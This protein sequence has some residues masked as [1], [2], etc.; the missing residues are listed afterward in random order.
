MQRL[1]LLKSQTRTVHRKKKQRLQIDFTAA[2]A[3]TLSAGKQ[4]IDVKDFIGII[5]RTSKDV[6][7]QILWI[8]SICCNRQFSLLT[9]VS[10]PNDSDMTSLQQRYTLTVHLVNAKA[11]QFSMDLS[12]KEATV[13]NIRSTWIDYGDG[14]QKNLDVV[15][16][17]A[18]TGL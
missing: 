8:L 18:P 6:I 9:Q 16:V 5:I 7:M 15:L 2:F 10:S 12:N 4:L 1:K 11:S 3:K 17:M 14:P 13:Q